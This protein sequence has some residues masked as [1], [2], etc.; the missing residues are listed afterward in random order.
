[1][2]IDILTLFPDM[3]NGP[4]SES[5]IKRAKEKGLV[6][7]NTHNIRDWANDKH[8][9]VDDEPYGGGPGMVMKVDVA[10]R[11]LEGVV[12]S[13]TPKKRGVRKILFTPKGRRFDQ[14]VAQEL[15]QYKRLVFVCGHYEGIDYR[16]NDYIDEEL[17]IGDYV[18]TGGELPAMVVTDALVRLIPGVV[19]NYSSV[20]EESFSSGILDYPHYTRPRDYNKSRVP[21]VLLSGHAKKINEWR[22]AKAMEL[23]QQNRPDLLPE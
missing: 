8:N 19:G 9:T 16:F 7:L 22:L 23:T 21:E 11:A 1:M 3:F 13:S 4:F 20:Q 15:L 18:L 6:Q 5:I 17:S 14:R 2:K 10:H 12:D